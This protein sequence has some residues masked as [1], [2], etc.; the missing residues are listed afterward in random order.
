MEALFQTY[1]TAN[2]TVLWLKPGASAAEE[3]GDQI[4]VDGSMPARVRG[5]ALSS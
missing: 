1:L 5:Q 4:R 2:S 3:I